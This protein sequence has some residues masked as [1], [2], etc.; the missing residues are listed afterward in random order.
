MVIKLKPLAGQ[1]RAMWEVVRQF[2]PYAVMELV[3]PGGTVLAFLYWLY[4]RRRGAM[5]TPSGRSL[6]ARSSPPISPVP[7]PA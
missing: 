7:E 4:R 2:A 6:R 3:L 1:I 5:V